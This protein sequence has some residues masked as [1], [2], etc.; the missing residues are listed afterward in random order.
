R[1]GHGLHGRTALLVAKDLRPD[2]PG[3]LGQARSAHHLR[4][5]HSDILAAIRGRLPGDAA[6]LLP[7]RSAISGAQRDVVGRGV[8]SR[9]RLRPA[10][11]L[12]PLVAWLWQARGTQS[13]A[14]HGAGV[15][16]TVAAAAGQLP[17]HSRRDRGALRLRQGGGSCPLKTHLWRTTSL[18]SAS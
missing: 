6:T 16:D 8:H 11:A 14:R 15:A 9:C 3:G 7:L 1:H 5:L 17:Y 12:F 18:T 4:W 13:V 2:V 10:A